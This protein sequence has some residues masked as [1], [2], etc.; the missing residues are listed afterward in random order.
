MMINEDDLRKL[1]RYKLVNER[2]F[3]GSRTG[4]GREFD[5]IEAIFNWAKGITKRG[6]N[7]GQPVLSPQRLNVPQLYRDKKKGMGPTGNV[8]KDTVILLPD[9]GELAQKQS[10]NTGETRRAFE[11]NFKELED[12]YLAMSNLSLNHVTIAGLLPT[13]QTILGNLKLPINKVNVNNIVNYYEDKG[14]LSKEQ[15]ERGE[16]PA[17]V[18]DFLM[19]LREK[20]TDVLRS[21][22]Q[23]GFLSGVTGA[24]V[25]EDLQAMLRDNLVD[26]DQ[27]DRITKFADRI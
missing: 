7:T 5:A 12:R 20:T 19:R 4:Q 24:G 8:N 16:L 22:L 15:R 26:Q 18:N 23:G 10:P 13:I 14:K 25:I 1:I 17:E 27:I 21:A 6:E 9:L 11:K 2:K 3:S